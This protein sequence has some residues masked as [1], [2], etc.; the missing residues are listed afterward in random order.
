[1]TTKLLP[2]LKYRERLDVVQTDNQVEQYLE[3]FCAVAAEIANRSVMKDF[4]VGGGDVK[5]R[6]IIDQRGHVL[7]G[8]VKDVMSKWMIE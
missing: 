7:E 3:S 8:E 4:I 1:M 5:M 2:K 6:T